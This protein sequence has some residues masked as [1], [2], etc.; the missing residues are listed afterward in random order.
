MA[1]CMAKLKRQTV[2][3]SWPRISDPV[4][5]QLSGQLGE[6]KRKIPHFHLAKGTAARDYAHFQ[7]L[8]PY[9]FQYVWKNF[10]ENYKFFVKN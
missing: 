7:A 10:K 6:K 5:P 4:I 1:G 3:I 8:L 9:Y 2:K